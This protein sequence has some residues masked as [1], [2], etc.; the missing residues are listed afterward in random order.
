MARNRNC[1]I[2]VEIETSILFNY[3]NKQTDDDTTSPDAQPRK[4]ITMETRLLGVSSCKAVTRGRIGKKSGYEMSHKTIGHMNDEQKQDGI[5]PNRNFVFTSECIT[6]LIYHVRAS[7]RKHGTANVWPWKLKWL[8]HSAWIRRLG[9]R[10]PPHVE[11]LS[12]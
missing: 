3:P 2:S 12:A 7:I 11:I 1:A 8:E 10:F 6:F 9:V 4:I 5:Y